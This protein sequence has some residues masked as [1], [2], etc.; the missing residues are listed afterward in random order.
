MSNSLHQ[1][2]LL[3]LHTSLFLPPGIE[4]LLLALSESQLKKVEKN[5]VR[6]TFHTGGLLVKY[7]T[8]TIP[9]DLHLIVPPNQWCSQWLH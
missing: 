5:Q 9:S 6:C 4:T 2:V 1:F 7:V 8:S 3:S